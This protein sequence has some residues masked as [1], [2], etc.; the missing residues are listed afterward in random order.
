[1]HGRGHDCCVTPA[2]FSTYV[3]CGAGRSRPRALSDVN[4]SGVVAHLGVGVLAPPCRVFHSWRDLPGCIMERLP[5]TE[6]TDS[7]LVLEGTFLAR[8]GALCSHVQHLWSLGTAE[9]G[10]RRAPVLRTFSLSWA[11][12]ANGAPP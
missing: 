11:S 1:M 6:S 2:G 3:V 9:R 7:K 8:P 10:R 4:F 5:Q 12:I